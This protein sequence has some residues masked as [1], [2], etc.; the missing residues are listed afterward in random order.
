[1]IELNNTPQG[2]LPRQKL[3]KN[4]KTEKWR[5]ECVEAGIRLITLD[6]TSRRSSRQDKIRNYS[7]Y[8]GHFDKADME[9]ELQH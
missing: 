2:G 3:S 8:N 6:A 7:L 5:K 9:T 4:R 1:M